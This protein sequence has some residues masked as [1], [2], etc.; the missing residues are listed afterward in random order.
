MKYPNITHLV[1]NFSYSDSLSEYNMSLFPH[2][3][4][5][6]CDEIDGLPCELKCL[7]DKNILLVTIQF[8]VTNQKSRIQI[9]QS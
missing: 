1:Q 2:T 3:I 9:N 8:Y 6:V 7:N 5:C 4:Q